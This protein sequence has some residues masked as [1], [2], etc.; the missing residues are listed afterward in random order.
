MPRHL[1]TSQAQ[2]NAAKEKIEAF[3]NG[4]S[5]YSDKE[6]WEAKER[7]LS[8]R[9]SPRSP[10]RQRPPPDRRD[11]QHHRSHGRLRPL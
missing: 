2:I 4:T 6:L 1:F 5:T 3:K 10:R 8:P 11:P 7:M 9:A